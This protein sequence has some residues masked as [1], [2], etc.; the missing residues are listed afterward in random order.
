MMKN[1]DLSLFENDLYKLKDSLSSNDIFASNMYRALCNM[2]WQKKDNEKIVYSC[3]WRY[4]GGLIAS[5]RDRGENYLNFYC[6]GLEGCVSNR[7][8]KELDI[9]GWKPLPYPEE[10]NEY[11]EYCV[12]LNEVDEY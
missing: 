2:M 11:E 7:V 4:A 8:K 12:G 1:D 9:L 3:T 5:I 6:S 10:G